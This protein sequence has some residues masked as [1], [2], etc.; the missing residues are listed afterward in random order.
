MIQLPRAGLCSESLLPVFTY[1]AGCCRSGLW[2]NGNLFVQALVGTH[3]QKCFHQDLKP[4]NVD[5]AGWS[6]AELGPNTVDH[7][8]ALSGSVR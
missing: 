3:M 1:V 2:L 4:D 5:V 7:N 6:E 8:R